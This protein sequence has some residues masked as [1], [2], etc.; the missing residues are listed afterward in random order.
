M[1]F[2][3]KNN[4]II[5]SIII[6]IKDLLK[7]KYNLE[8][9]IVILLLTNFYLSMINIISENNNLDTRINL[10]ILNILHNFLRIF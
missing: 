4:F 9:S 2:S 1:L 6:L 7:I 5:I 10:I 3:F 8:F